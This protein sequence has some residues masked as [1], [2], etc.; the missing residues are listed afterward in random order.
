[1]QISD[2]SP[3]VCSTDLSEATGKSATAVGSWVDRD[4]DNIIDG[5]EVVLASGTNSSA[6][7]SGAQA[8][9]DNTIASGAGSRADVVG[10]S[11]YGVGC[12]AP[13]SGLFG[14]SRAFGAQSQ[15]RGQLSTGLGA[16]RNDKQNT[17]LSG[18][19]V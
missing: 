5:D 9:A 18:G 19:G 11:A 17:R 14:G 2:G 3:D 12:V 10:S 13:S 15:V 1:M 4:G 7:G 6:F 8:T 16:G